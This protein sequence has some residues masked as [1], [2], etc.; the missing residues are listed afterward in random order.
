[1]GA[2]TLA[3]ALF[4]R[5]RSCLGHKCCKCCKCK[6]NR[7]K[8]LRNTV[9]N[10]NIQ[11]DND[12]SLEATTEQPESNTSEGASVTTKITSTAMIGDTVIPRVDEGVCVEEEEEDDNMESRELITGRE[13]NG[14]SPTDEG[15]NSLNKHMLHKTKK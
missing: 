4:F 5:C 13:H 3:V 1:M 12:V 14:D 15:Y 9:E 10:N 8:A 2:I 7:Y 11:N 6:C